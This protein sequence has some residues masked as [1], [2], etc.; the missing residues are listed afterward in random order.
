MAAYLNSVPGNF[1]VPL[2]F[3]YD[4]NVARADFGIMTDG[5]P[6]ILNDDVLNVDEETTAHVQDGMVITRKNES[7]SQKRDADFG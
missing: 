6:N 4:K 5:K 7:Q 1:T 3:Q 2:F